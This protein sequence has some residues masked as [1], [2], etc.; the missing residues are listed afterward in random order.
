MRKTLTSLVAAAGFVAF[1]GPA[2]AEGGC[3]GLHS[4]QK[5]GTEVASTDKSTKPV[6]QTQAPTTKN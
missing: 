5:T 1:A 4:A 3:G 2:L 6:Q